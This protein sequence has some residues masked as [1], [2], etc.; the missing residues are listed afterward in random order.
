MDEKKELKARKKAYNKAKKKAVR[1]WSI[2]ACVSGPLAIIMTIV[3]VVCTMFDNT[4]V[5]F[6]GG[7]FWELVNEDKNAIYFKG[8]FETEADRTAAGA[9]LVYQVEAEGAA[10]LTNEDGALPL[11]KGSKVSLF[12]TSSV[13][14]SEYIGESLS[15]I[16]N[17]SISLL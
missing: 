15:L 7:T 8:D 6:A 11:A 4:I 9:A 1:P 2:L 5:L 16:S 14:I 13:N 10:L 17:I 12:S 3:A